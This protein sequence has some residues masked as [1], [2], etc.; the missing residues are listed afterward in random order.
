MRIVSGQFRGRTIITPDTSDTRPTMDKTRQAVFNIL[1]SASWAMRADG[2]PILSGARV[3]DVFA[4]SGALGLE[5]LSQG[6]AHSVFI[7]QAPAALAAIKKNIAA[8]KL[9]P[10]TSILSH[11]ALTLPHNAAAPFDMIFLDPP[12]DDGVLSRAVDRLITHAYAAMG[13]LLVMEMRKTDTPH[14]D[15]RL[16]ML[17]ER[18][19]GM[20]RIVFT[21]VV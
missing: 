7:E 12:Y 10:R 4:G 14:N 9:E 16:S 3:L 21:T 20:A 13:T 8:M 11:N 1:R 15:P 19:Y 17:D 2:T 5:A 18:R 6:A